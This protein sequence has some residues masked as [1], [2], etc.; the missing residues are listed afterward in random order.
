MMIDLAFPEASRYT[1]AMPADAPPH[2]T[3][4]EGAPA[5]LISVVIPSYNRQHCLAGAIGSVIAQTYRPIEIIVV[6]DG[7]TD[8]TIARFAEFT[9]AV[10][11][12]FHALE[13][14][15]GAAIARNIGVDLARG[16]FVA[17][18]DSDDLWHPE[19]IARQMRALDDCG[20]DYGGCYTGI[21]SVTEQGQVCGVS[22]ATAQGD[23]HAALLNHN[24]VGSTS[25]VLVR[26]DLLMQQNGFLPGLR[27]CQDWELWTRL[28]RITRF[29][30]VPELLT[31]LTIATQ[32]RITTNG[33]NRLSGHLYMYR[34]HLRPAFRAGLADPGLFR[35]ILGEVFMQTGRPGYAARLLGAN[36]R[37]KPLSAKRLVMFAMAKLH[38]SKGRFFGV[39]ELIGRVENRLR[40]TPIRVA[41]P[42]A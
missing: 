7:S 28:A 16:P 20:P 6:D 39:S 31:T 12:L 32:G 13:R 41:A 22:R 2:A 30:C 15:M 33:R 14:N 17:F 42:E 18:L 23:I 34:T 19:K 8:G 35:A 27:S 37:A 1:N 25:C 5:P 9:C 29:A 21:L 38:V 11:F 24:V 3:L 26:R 4:A 10:P 36:W 40:P